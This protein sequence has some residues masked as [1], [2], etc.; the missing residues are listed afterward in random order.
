VWSEAKDLILL[1]AV[2]GIKRVGQCLADT[3]IALMCT[4]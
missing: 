1:T 3:Y 4:V 2:V